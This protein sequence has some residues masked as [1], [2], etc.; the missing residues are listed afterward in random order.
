MIELLSFERESLKSPAIE[1]H[2]AEGRAHLH[3]RRGRNAK[4][5]DRIDSPQDVVRTPMGSSDVPEPANGDFL[6]VAMEQALWWLRREFRAQPLVSAGR[7]P[8][9]FGVTM[10]GF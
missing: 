7:P 4:T 8:G 1:P 10:N 6:R 3:N 5:P 9:A 2:P